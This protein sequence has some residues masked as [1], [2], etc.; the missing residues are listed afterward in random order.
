MRLQAQTAAAPPDVLVLSNGDTLHGKFVNAIDGKVT[1]HCD[2]LGDITLDWDKIKELHTSG[3][4]AVFNKNE[5]YRERKALPLFPP[6]R[7]KWQISRSPCTRKTRQAPRPFQSPT[8]NSSWTK[9]PWTSS[10]IIIP[11]SSAGG[12]EQRPPALPLSRQ[13]RI[14]YAIS[15][16]LDLVRVVPTAS[17]LS[18]RNR[19]SVGFIGSYGKITQPAYTIPGH[20]SNFRS[21]SGHQVRSLPR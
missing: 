9:P 15:G 6:A 17:W 2:P 19:T 18:P 4:F 10:S 14:Q 16:A 11:A 13:P 12:M 7:S 8:R 21:R 3:D 20:A 5:K 1:F